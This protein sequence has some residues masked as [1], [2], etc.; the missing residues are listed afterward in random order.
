SIT[1]D[2]S[3]PA[4]HRVPRTRNNKDPQA[5]TAGGCGEDKVKDMLGVRR[6]LCP[7]TFLKNTTSKWQMMNKDFRAR[8]CCPR[9]ERLRDHSECKTGYTLLHTQDR[10]EGCDC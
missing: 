4:D 7:K 9:R 10:D 2:E 1:G 8:G 6:K 3:P 5:L